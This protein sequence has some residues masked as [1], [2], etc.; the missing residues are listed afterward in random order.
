MCSKWAILITQNPLS[1]IAVFRAS[2]EFYQK[3]FL[4]I[5]AIYNEMFY[6]QLKSAF[7]YILVAIQVDID[8]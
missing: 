8:V 2:V 1:A 7:L 3:P 5:V 6:I 4:N